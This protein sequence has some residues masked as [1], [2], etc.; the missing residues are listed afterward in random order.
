MIHALQLDSSV[1]R[2]QTRSK[3]ARVTRHK[4]PALMKFAPRR[5]GAAE[6]NLI[7]A[8]YGRWME[9]NIP[10]E[11]S[12]LPDVSPGTRLESSSAC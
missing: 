7:S 8:H 5:V 6:S 4:S 3:H 12:D 1:A 9:D 10:N 11:I 2:G